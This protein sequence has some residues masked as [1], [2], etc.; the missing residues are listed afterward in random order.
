MR[1]DGRQIAWLTGR[2]RRRLA[3]AIEGYLYISPWILG[4][5]LFTGG[6]VVASF[7]LSF[8][9]WRMIEPPRWVGLEN[10]VT[11]IT[12]DPLFTKSLVVTVNYVVVSVPL[13]IAFALALAVLV[14]Q[15]VRLV[16][17][18]RTIF[19][20]PSVVS[21]VAVSVLWVWLLNPEYGLVNDI[22]SFFGITGP[23][24]LTS[25]RYA[26]PALIGISLWNVGGAMVIFL[27][28]LQG[29]PSELIEAAE[30]DGAEGLTRFR[31][32]TLPLLS[33]VTFFNL[34]LAVIGG[35]QTFTQAFVMTQGGPLNATLLYALYLYQN[36]FAFLKMGYAAA[37]AWFMF[38][39]ILVITLIQFRLARTWVY[40]EAGSWDR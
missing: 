39:I 18:W 29:I 14:N 38:I 16:G 37:L 10:Y 20:M 28:G 17:V 27:A 36:A 6:P 15:K 24:W 26:L 31:Y 33:P 40:Y 34:V 12:A 22:L 2:R 1:G 3:Q 5:I 19:Y 21:G 35:V 13:Q 25:E 8:F 30:L 11:M 4:F 23:D 9:E 7:V 32:V